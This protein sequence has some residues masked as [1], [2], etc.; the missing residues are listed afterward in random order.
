MEN[1]NWIATWS[2][3]P[4]NVWA[5]DAVVYGFHHQTVRQVLRV[6][7]GGKRLRIRLSNECG[8][9]AIKIGSVALAKAGTGGSIQPGSHRQ[10]TFG[11][12][13]EALLVPA[14]PLLSDAVELQVADLEQIA[15]SIYFPEFAPIETYHYEAQQTAYISDFGDSTGATELPLQQTS[16]SR[17]LLTAVLVECHPGCGSIVCL[18]D[19][20]TDGFGSTTD[21][22]ARWPDQLAER[23]AA[24]GR[25]R[26]VSVLNQGIG[27]NRLLTSRGR[28]L[29]A[30]ARFDRDVLSFPAVKWLAVLEGINDIGWPETM[31]AGQ[32]EVV[33]AQ[34]LS[35]A[36][37]Q[38]MVRARLHGI[39][40]LLGT[41]PPFEN[42]QEGLPL[43]TFYSPSKERKRKEANEWIRKFSEADA[44]VDLDRALADPANPS[45]LLP[46][47]DCGDH[48]HPSDAGYREIA[49][50]FDR[51][52]DTLL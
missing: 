37:R 14:A 42:V 5:G 23:L 35:S 24:R 27:G 15:V 20:I 10:L 4:M 30:L 21:G 36:Y 6:S 2:A 29:S 3:S 32:E 50:E 41:L 13:K 9:T 33:S 1:A 17:Y 49:K 34:Q 43:R 52:L 25:L 8:A 31:L 19:S 11:G 40:V 46:A 28:G 16:T 45:M 7:K 12:E 48:L 39:K 18:G 38:L 26:D 44:V 22:N 51:A 47:F